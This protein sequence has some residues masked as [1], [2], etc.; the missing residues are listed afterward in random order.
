MFANYHTHTFRCGHASGTEREYIENAIRGGFKI[1][2]FSD[3]APFMFP[4]GRESSFRVPTFMAQ[5]YFETLQALREEYKDRIKI[6]IGFEMEYYPKY[7]DRML[8]YAKSF[9]SEYLILGQHFISNEDPGSTYSGS[10]CTDEI[11]IVEYAD[12][13]I[14]AMKTGEFSYIAHPDVFNF[15]GD[16]AIR[17]REWRRICVAA[18]EM[19]IPLE[20][21]FLG[22][23]TG[24]HYPAA[25]FWRVAGEEKPKV[26]FGLDAHE[27]VDTV[28]EK[29]L[30]IAKK[31]VDFYGL[32]LIDKLE[33]D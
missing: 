25:D 13:L 12:C 30:A 24:R 33:M 28:D 27:V 6:H 11:K 14:E 23:R 32:P 2:G 7:F 19:D 9:G 10:P 31:A 1:L 5:D 26:I 4:D 16:K 21:N 22:I 17:E 3:H 18:R 20:I 15:V 29:S 8:K